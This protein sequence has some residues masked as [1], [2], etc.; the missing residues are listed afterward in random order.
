MHYTGTLVDGT[1]F[2]SSRDRNQPFNFGRTYF[3]LMLPH[4]EAE[5]DHDVMFSG[6]R[7]SHQRVVLG[8]STLL[9]MKVD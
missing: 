9:I 6:S 1:K 8:F 4:V 2:D 3:I 7:T 5:T